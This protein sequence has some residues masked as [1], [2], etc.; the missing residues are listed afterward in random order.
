MKVLVINT[1]RFKLNGI[2]AV[3]KN[4]YQAMDKKNL[5]MDF[6]AID[7]PSDEYRCFF[8]TNHLR[9]FVFHKKNIDSYF[10][11][12]LNLC[13]KE[14][15]DI[16]HIHG[17]SANMAIELFAVTLGGVKVRIAH[18]H[19][20]ATMHPFMHNLLWPMFSKLCTTRLACG[21]DAG[22]WL[23]RDKNFTV[24]NNGI[25]TK[26]YAFS[27]EKRNTVR[28][29]LGIQDD[30]IL[31]GHVGNFIEQKNHSFLIDIFSEVHSEN[32]KFKLL[33]ISDG[34]L[35]PI[36]KD[37]VYSLG[38]DD[39]VIFL[40]KTLKVSEYLQGMDLFL[41]PSLHE[42]LP[43]VL[44]EAQ[45]AG[46]ICAVSNT[47]AKEADLT[48]TSVFLPI[49]STAPWAE[50]VKKLGYKKRNREE[51]STNNIAL[52]KEKGYDIEQNADKLRQIY[53]SAC[54]ER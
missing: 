1:V 23:Y 16:V 43:V 17:N 35:M 54:E 4:Y 48:E 52:I 45:A 42:G 33:L 8:E 49:N 13:R 44:V 34:M 30:E 11:K 40:G 50:A 36:I 25:Q 51:D 29:E 27:E 10:C 5:Q 47:V 39:A 6:V 2:S 38:L 3:I 18:S 24:L 14:K 19:N 41:L 22:K 32:P 53:V 21:E 12:I 7:D 26:D 28:K 20:T 15:Y 46:L 31:L 37:K 9:C